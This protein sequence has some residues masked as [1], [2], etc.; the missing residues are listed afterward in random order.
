LLFVTLIL[1]GTALAEAETILRVSALK[2]SHYSPNNSDIE[3][4][5]A[6]LLVAKNHQSYNAVEK[7]VASNSVESALALLSSR[8]TVEMSEVCEVLVGRRAKLAY[9]AIISLYQVCT[10]W[11][12]AS[13]FG[14][15]ASGLL[16]L[17][18]VASTGGQSCDVYAHHKDLGEDGA[19]LVLYRSWVAVFALLVLPLSLLDPKEQ[20]SFQVVM[21]GVRL[22]MVAAMVASVAAVSLLEAFADEAPNATSS[23]SNVAAQWFGSEV[24]R[25]R[26]E[27]DAIPAARASGIFTAFSI[28][29]KTTEPRPFFIHS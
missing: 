21:T 24:A 15:A 29:V 19:C 14:E 8:R 18:W 1:I 7:E 9:C 27:S 11:S 16:A 25:R 23:G 3:C 10:L 13:V 22:A 17:P 4:R 20:A 26:D 6:S 28:M 5:E 12:Y 2:D